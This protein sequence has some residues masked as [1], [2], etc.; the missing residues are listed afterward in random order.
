MAK[1]DWEGINNRAEGHKFT[2]D[3]RVSD[4]QKICNELYIELTELRENCFLL[5]KAEATLKYFPKS[6]KVFI[7]GKYSKIEGGIKK[8]IKS[9]FKEQ[10][11]FQLKHNPFL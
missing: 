9:H 3:Y 5:T 8:Y 1:E 4:L 11:D 10:I 6:K 2:I 7:N